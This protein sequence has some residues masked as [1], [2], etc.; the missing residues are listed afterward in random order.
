MPD[1]RENRRMEG[2][3][4]RQALQPP[5]S[6]FMWRIGADQARNQTK[7]RSYVDLSASS[8]KNKF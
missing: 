6:R 1:K 5:I 4:W 7:G 2:L 3:G 8:N